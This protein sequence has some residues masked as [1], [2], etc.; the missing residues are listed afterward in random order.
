M[1]E[2]IKMLI[3][4]F[5]L[6]AV[7]T[8]ALVGVDRFTAP[9]IAKYRAGI[10]R[11]NVLGTLGIPFDDANI[12]RVFAENIQ[13][14]KR[15][16]KDIYKSKS[17]EIAFGFSGAGAQDIIMGVM[18]LESDLKTI[19]G[20]AVTEQKETPGLGDRVLAQD[21]LA[22]FLGKKIVPGLAITAQGKASGD[23]EVDG[24]TGATL[25]SK[26]FGKILNAEAAKYAAL[27]GRDAP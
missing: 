26:A 12:D 23:C 3:F 18:A 25:T 9:M 13:V 21:N 5:V 15:D 1:R 2:K 4:V 6:G 10:L 19:K 14:L 11:R 22:K 8:T 16:A 7:W 20:L 24:I 27:I 17:G